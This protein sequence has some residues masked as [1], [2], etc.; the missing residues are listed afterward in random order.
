MFGVQGDLWLL[1]VGLGL[2]TS[3]QE[4]SGRFVADLVWVRPGSW[5]DRGSSPRRPAP[6]GG[7]GGSALPGVIGRLPWLRRLDFDCGASVSEAKIGTRAF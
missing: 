1:L 7:S 5:A 2:E 4:R 6:P 3:P